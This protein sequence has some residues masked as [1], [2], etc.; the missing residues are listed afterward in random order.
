M[1]ELPF[2]RGKAHMASAPVVADLI[3]GG[4]QVSAI[5]SFTSGAPLTVNTPGATLG[6]GWDTRSQ[7]HGRSESVE[8]GSECVVQYGPFFRSAALPVRE[9]GDGNP[10]KDP[11]D[12]YW[13]S[14]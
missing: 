3:L 6:N 1:Y 11:A 9:F 4:W 2:G 7:S 12:M 13:I 14:G 10:R 5:N 8:S